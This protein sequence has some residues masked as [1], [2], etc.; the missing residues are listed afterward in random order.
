MKLDKEYIKQ[1][2][3]LPMDEAVEKCIKIAK[4]RIN[5]EVDF[6]DTI[7]NHKFLFRSLGRQIERLNKELPVAINSGK[8]IRSI[9]H[10]GYTIIDDK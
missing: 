6:A 2:D 3:W 10:P 8:S 9:N 5:N 1:F 7:A 4:E